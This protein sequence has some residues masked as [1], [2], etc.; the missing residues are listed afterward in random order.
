M[1]RVGTRAIVLTIVT[2][3]VLVPVALAYTSASGRV[4]DANGNPWTYGGT[5]VCVQN[6][7]QVVIGSGVVNP[8]GTWSVTLGS[9]SAATCTI[10]PAAGPGG[11]PASFTCAIPGGGGGGVQDYSCGDQ[12]TGTSPT[13]VSLSSFSGSG[14]AWGWLIVPVAAVAAT[15]LIVL[16]RH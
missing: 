10:D 4:V 14:M 1:R 13:A 7:N 5:V 9:P 16:L 12:S 2:L 15:A 3:L 8:D 11:D 6:T